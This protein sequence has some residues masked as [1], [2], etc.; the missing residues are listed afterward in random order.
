MAT[1]RSL[2]AALQYGQYAGRP[3]YSAAREQT[4]SWRMDGATHIAESRRDRGTLSVAEEHLDKPQF[5]IFGIELVELF[6]GVRWA[7]FD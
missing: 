3:A 5:E 4:T 7:E 2:C 6:P 1:E